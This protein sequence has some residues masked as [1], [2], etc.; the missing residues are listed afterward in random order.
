MRDAVASRVALLLPRNGRVDLA[1]QLFDAIKSPD[2]RRSLAATLHYHYTNTD[3]NPDKAKHY[4]DI[5]SK[6]G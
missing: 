6:R 3:P 4:K 2:A 5:L 1:E